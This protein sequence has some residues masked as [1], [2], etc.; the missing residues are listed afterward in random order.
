MRKSLVLKIELLPKVPINAML[1]PPLYDFPLKLERD[2]KLGGL[3]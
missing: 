3:A 2:S 1:L